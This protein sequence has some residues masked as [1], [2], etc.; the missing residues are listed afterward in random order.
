MVL[1]A[2]ET[3]EA[4]EADGIGSSCAPAGGLAATSTVGE[5]PHQLIVLL[6]LRCTEL[7][8]RKEET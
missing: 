1:A 3:S 8:R 7:S 2:P 6:D 4:E 5:A